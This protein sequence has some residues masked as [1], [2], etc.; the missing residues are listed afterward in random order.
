MPRHDATAL[1]MART[2]G[3]RIRQPAL[4]AG[5]SRNDPAARRQKSEFLKVDGAVVD[6]CGGG[7]CFAKGYTGP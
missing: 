7:P 6:V 2:I 1:I 5:G 4:A 3:A